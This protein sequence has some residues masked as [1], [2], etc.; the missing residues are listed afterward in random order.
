M[1]L[2]KMEMGEKRERQNEQC[3]NNEKMLCEFVH[4]Q[5]KTMMRQVR[6]ILQVFP[7]VP[8]HLQ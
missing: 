4:Q 3:M 5:V 1:A 6:Q 2:R 7:T 8:H